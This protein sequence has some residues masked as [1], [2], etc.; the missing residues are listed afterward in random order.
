VQ[1]PDCGFKRLQFE[2]NLVR[3]TCT[4]SIMTERIEK[5]H[6]CKHNK[7]DKSYLPPKRFIPQ[8][9]VLSYRTVRKINICN[10]YS[11]IRFCWQA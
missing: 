11:T 4:Y 10:M 6:F 2:D 5:Y 8:D 3:R 7:H 1:Q 9:G